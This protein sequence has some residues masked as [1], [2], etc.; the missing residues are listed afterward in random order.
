M[1]LR[2]GYYGTCTSIFL[3]WLFLLLN[4]TYRPASGQKYYFEQYSSKEGLSASKVY[5]I[6]QDANDFIWLGT[7]SGITRF[8]GLRFENFSTSDSLAPG[9]VKSIYEDSQGRI[10]LGHIGGGMTLFE[11]NAFK[12]ISFQSSIFIDIDSAKADDGKSPVLTL[13][14][15][16]TAITEFDGSLWLATSLGGALRL[17]NPEQGVTMM[18]GKQYLGRHGLSNDA[19]GFCIDRNGNLY[20]ITDVGI[21]KYDHASDRFVPYN[22]EGLTKYFL[23][24]TMFEDSKGNLWFGTYNG[25][26]YRLDR[27]SG[28][29]RMFDTRNGLRG[30]FVT[31]ITEDYRGNIWASS[32]EDWESR[33]GITVFSPEGTMIFN[34]QNGLLAEHIL[35]M[36]EDKERNMLIADRDAGL[37][38]YKGDH[39][40]SF[41][42]PEFL[43]TNDVT[44]LA[45]DPTGLCW[46]GTRQGLSQFNPQKKEGERIRTVVFPPNMA[47]IQINIIKPDN[48]GDVWIVTSGDEVFRYDLKEGNYRY[49]LDLNASLQALRIAALETDRMNNLWLGTDRALI[50]WNEKKKECRTY[51]RINGL[52]GNNITSLFCDDKGYL[53][54]GT[55]ERNGLTRH[56]PG[57]DIFTAVS[58]GA[59]VRPTCI[60]ETHDGSV[61][62]GTIDGLYC[63]RDDTVCRKLT[64]A[65]GLLMNSINLLQHR[66]EW[67]HRHRDKTKCLVCRQRWRSVVRYRLRGYQAQPVKAATRSDRACNTYLENTGEL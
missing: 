21:K 36:I 28:E 11:N 15:D 32:M 52:T 45:Q 46:F 24:I 1:P 62:V 18:T 5:T 63:L 51:T 54:I 10:W 64:E 59:D 42:A 43:P 9:G 16:I 39:F 65:D 29:M 57:T 55:E 60:T 27:E 8:D 48:N 35:C 3:A 53:W 49:D 41:L 23:T 44:T 50:S 22:P 17:N 61:W 40:T 4:V 67:L 56:L 25:G 7:A 14:G 20:C 38:I 47:G 58:F 30:N 34:N 12:R 26:L 13:D 31:Y 37:F 2:S 19:F 66:E 6:I 33:G